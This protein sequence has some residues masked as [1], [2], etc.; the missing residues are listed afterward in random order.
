MHIIKNVPLNCGNL[1][2][3]LCFI[4]SFAIC[5]PKKHHQNRGDLGV[6][7]SW[8]FSKRVSKPSI[9]EYLN[10]KL[11]KVKKS[12]KH[13]KSLSSSY[14]QLCQVPQAT[15]IR[16]EGTLGGGAVVMGRK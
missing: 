4:A 15:I 1:P 8:S 12:N 6:S 14:A 5:P 2:S 3:H 9:L 11:P 10:L 7:T 16:V 13:I